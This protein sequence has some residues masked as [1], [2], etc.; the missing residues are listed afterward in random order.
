MATVHFRYRSGFW[1]EVA[2]TI[3]VPTA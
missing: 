3:D 2:R 1:L